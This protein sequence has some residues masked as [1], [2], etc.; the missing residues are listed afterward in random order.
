MSNQFFFFLC[1]CK[2]FHAKIN[3]NKHTLD[4]RTFNT[5]IICVIVFIYLV[6][7]VIILGISHLFPIERRKI[8]CLFFSFFSFVL[9][10]RF[11]MRTIRLNWHRLMRYQTV[12]SSF[13]WD[14]KWAHIIAVM[15]RNVLNLCWN[16]S[17]IK[18]IYKSIPFCLLFV[19]QIVC[20]NFS[21][22][23]I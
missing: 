1:L 21:S 13:D 9:F 5:R 10:H 7:L 2:W 16:F 12:I 20:Q 11:K 17:L 18:K 8:Q 3:N 19:N 23:I 15:F 4:K 14:A 22:I 6:F